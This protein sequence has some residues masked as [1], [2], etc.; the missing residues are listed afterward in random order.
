MKTHDYEKLGLKA[1][2]EIHQRLRTN[3]LFCGCSADSS[4]A[5]QKQIHRRLRAVAGELGAVDPAALYEYTR[6]REFDYTG[7]RNATC[8]VELDE[9][10]PH[11]VNADALH[12]ALQVAKTLS[13][14]IPQ[15]LHV[16]RKTVIDGSNT[17]G[18]QR[19]MVVGLG[20]FLETSFGRVGV[21]SVALEEESAQILERTGRTV[22]YGLDRLGI[23]LVEIGTAPDMHTPAQAREVAE[24][25][26]ALLR[27][28]G[29]VQRGI[30]T[31]RQDV[32]VSIRGGARVEIKGFQ[33]L[34]EIERLI[35]NE[36]ERQASLLEIAEILR[37]SNASATSPVDTTDVFTKTENRMLSK[38]VGE[39]KRVYAFVLKGFGG[40]LKRRISGERTFGREL[41]DYA[42]AM[43]AGMIHSDEQL[44]TYSLT[45]EF[46]ALRERMGAS[47]KDVVCIVAAD[48]QTAK[49]ACNAVI[50]RAL[51]ALRGVPAETRA[52]NPDVTTSY[53]RPLPGGARMYPE[54]DVPPIV[55]DAKLLA[56]IK[57]PESL[58]TKKERFIALGMSPQTAQELV[59]SDMLALFEDAMKTGRV[60][61]RRAGEVLTSMMTALRREGTRVETIRNEE[62]IKLLR[63]LDGLPKESV[64]EVLARM[65]QGKSYEEASRIERIDLKEL[66][67]LVEQVVK[68]N[69][70]LINKEGDAAFKKLMGPLMERVRGRVE[71]E[72][73]AAALKK[74]LR[75]VL[76]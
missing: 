49:K 6:G 48:E 76:R 13:C 56:S 25:L 71:G 26:G 58:E 47:G 67:K 12:V 10:P 2:I 46:E 51:Y 18:F 1:G 70:G 17:S 61:V 37:E 15:E 64:P 23:P 53:A 44:G 32:N 14:D 36:V 73:V 63:A 68:E 40:L 42:V 5:L 50:E 35:E 55:I 45:R 54:T 57:R 9:E 65:A 20:G 39:G 4:E 69:I 11:P 16:M 62:L 7:Y 52:P 31:I 66:E 27:S 59:N 60:N 24:T 19:T 34:R 22:R 28:T 43:R 30:G 72:T 21:T 41:A 33:E 74:R 8:L 29:Q 75:S 38:A 3:K